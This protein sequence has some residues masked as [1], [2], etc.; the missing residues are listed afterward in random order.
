M[1]RKNIIRNLAVASMGVFSLCSCNDFLTITPSDKTVL[2]DYWK[3]KDDVD[4]VVA[5]AYYKM[6]S[7]DIIERFIMWG[8]YRSDELQKY[9]SI[10]STDLDNISNLDLYPSCGYN[11]WAAFYSVIN[12]CNLVMKHAP[13]VMEIDPNYTSGDNQSVRAQMLALRAL[14]HYYLIRTFRDVPY[15]TKAYE[16]TDEMELDGQLPP[17][18]TLQMCIADL[19]E[20]EQGC[21][22]YD[23]N[24]WGIG[25]WRNYGLMSKDAVYATLADIYL[26][27]G[28]M[29]AG[30]DKAKSKEYYQKCIDYVDKILASHKN[31]YYQSHNT[32]PTATNPFGLIDGQEAFYNI[33][34]EGN[35]EESIL[36]LQFNG[37]NTSNSKVCNY[38]ARESENATHGLLVGTTVVGS[39]LSDTP[40]PASSSS[41]T[42]AYYQSENDLRFYDNSYGVN[43]GTASA[44]EVRKMVAQP[45]STMSTIPSNGRGYTYAQTRAY[46]KYRQNWIVYRITDLI[47]MEAE[48]RIQLA[49]TDDAK[50]QS[51]FTYVNA[52]NKRSI[53]DAYKSNAVDTLVYKDNY[54]SQKKMEMLCLQERGRELCFEGKRWY[55]LVRYSYRHMTGVDPT[56]TLYEIDPNGSLYPSLTDEGN[57]LTTILATRYLT[58]LFKL[59]NEGYL[60]WPIRHSET[61]N[62]PLIQQNPV[63]VETKT[64]ER[65]EE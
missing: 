43:S 47:L 50:L 56:K 58:N 18:S 62:N 13:S 7:G 4:Q 23:K 2:E 20:A 16:N 5:G 39:P 60:Y 6:L 49:G 14:C 45:Q 53:Y 61:K 11:S 31:F 44:Y 3:S 28:S 10:S 38:Y 12:T 34:V 22:K 17:D 21:Y 40:T 48:A 24:T 63:W 42:A 29:W 54:N 46:S 52:V 33:F 8:D 59:R 57:E 1:T 41:S 65:T 9:Q 32:W 26:W 27:R 35:S 64:S 19:E 30:T 15:V 51:A 25:D 55:D 36:E 37:E